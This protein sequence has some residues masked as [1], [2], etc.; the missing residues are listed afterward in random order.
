[1]KYVFKEKI[2]KIILLVLDSMEVLKHYKKDWDLGN[3]PLFTHHNKLVRGISDFFLKFKWKVRLEKSGSL[4][5]IPQVINR[6]GGILT[7]VPYDLQTYVSF[8]VGALI[9]IFI[10]AK[11]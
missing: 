6:W 9:F 3:A 7:Q 1:M 2:T 11:V 4:L 10:L 5:K 8:L